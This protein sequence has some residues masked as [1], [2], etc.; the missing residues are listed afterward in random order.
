MEGQNNFAPEDSAL[1]F[2]ES[3][4]NKSQQKWSAMVQLIEHRPETCLQ[5]NE[6]GR[7]AENRLFRHPADFN[8]WGSI[9]VGCDN[10]LQQRSSCG[11]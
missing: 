11:T 7:D 2:W 6:S 8:D 9:G 3:R 5:E 4:L 1:L 10:K